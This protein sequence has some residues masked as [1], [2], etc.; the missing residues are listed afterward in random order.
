MPIPPVIESVS[1]VNAVGSYGAE[2]VAWCRAELGEAPR[3]WQAYVA[4]RVLEH[5]A[6]GQLVHRR[7]GITVPRQVGK[8]VLLRMLAAWR[9]HQA[10]AVR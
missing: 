6:E 2:F 3:P 8:S 4:A 5:D 7:V 9:M 10:D 1:N